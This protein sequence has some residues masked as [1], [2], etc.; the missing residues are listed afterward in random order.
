M[1]LNVAA[2]YTWA[3]VHRCSLEAFASHIGTSVSISH[4]NTCTHSMPNASCLCLALWYPYAAVMTM[5]AHEFHTCA[6][7]SQS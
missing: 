2:F 7:A 6:E 4:V 1:K 3:V 5:S